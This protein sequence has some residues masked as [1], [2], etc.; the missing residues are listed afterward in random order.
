MTGSAQTRSGA[1]RFILLLREKN[2]GEDLGEESVVEEIEAS[3]EEEEWPSINAIPGL[4]GS[5]PK[6]R[7]EKIQS[8]SRPV[9]DDSSDT[10]S[11]GELRFQDE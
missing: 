9:A 1:V 4:A 11:L 10:S 3:D 5:E 7:S 2:K 8:S 6:S